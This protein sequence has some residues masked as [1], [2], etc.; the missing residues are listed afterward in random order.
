MCDISVIQFGIHSKTVERGRV[1][2]LQVSNVEEGK[3]NED[4]IYATTST[5][6]SA[7]KVND[8]LLAAKGGKTKAAIVPEQFSGSVASSSLFIIRLKNKNEV[9][10]GYLHWYLNLP[11]TQWT[12]KKESTGTKIPALSIKH[13]RKLKIEI[14]PLN[15]QKKII[16]LKELQKNE[17]EILK[18]LGIKR[19]ILIEAVTKKLVTNDEH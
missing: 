19:K 17:E 9:L 12:L 14:P 1:P 5:T 15:T 18:E 3:I 10:P 11:R 16:E 6:D 13:L 7:L 4:V 2:Y 8:L